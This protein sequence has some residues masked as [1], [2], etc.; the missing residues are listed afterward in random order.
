VHYEVQVNGVPTDPLR[1]V[2]DTPRAPLASL[3]DTRRGS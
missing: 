1:Y 3:L 2:I